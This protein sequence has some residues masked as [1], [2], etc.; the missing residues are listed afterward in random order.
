VVSL[1]SSGWDQVVHTRYGRQANCGCI[2]LLA[3]H[4]LPFDNLMNE[5]CVRLMCMR[6]IQTF[7]Y[8]CNQ[9]RVRLNLKIKNL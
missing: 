7:L 1:L 9:L 5:D 2:S 6:F 3:D 8:L 4:R